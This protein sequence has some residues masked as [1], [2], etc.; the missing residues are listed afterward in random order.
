MIALFALQAGGGTGV[1]TTALELI[2]G[3]NIVTKVVLGEVA[4]A[5]VTDIDPG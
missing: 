4:S 2:L 1:P 5:S 3:G